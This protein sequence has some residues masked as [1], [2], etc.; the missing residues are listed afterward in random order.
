METTQVKSNSKHQTKN[1]ICYCK[2]IWTQKEFKCFTNYWWII[3]TLFVCDDCLK[4]VGE[5]PRL[6]RKRSNLKLT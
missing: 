2:K 3:R 6:N 5:S 4:E 1:K